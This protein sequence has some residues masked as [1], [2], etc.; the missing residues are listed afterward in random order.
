MVSL[1]KNS[2]LSGSAPYLNFLVAGGGCRAGYKIVLENCLK[3]WGGL[4]VSGYKVKKYEN[5]F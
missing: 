2:G 3:P 1:K 4:L 5:C